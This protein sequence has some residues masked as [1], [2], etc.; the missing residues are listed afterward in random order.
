MRYRIEMVDLTQPTRVTVNGRPLAE[1][2]PGSDAAGWSYQPATAT[3]V[4]DTPELPTTRA[5]SV[6]ASG[7]RPVHRPEPPTPGFGS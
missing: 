6:A 2:A 7:S 3:V 5:A 4:V 1:T